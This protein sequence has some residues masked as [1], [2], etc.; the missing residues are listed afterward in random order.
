MDKSVENTEDGK[1]IISKEFF[2]ELMRDKTFLDCLMFVG[3]NGWEGYEVAKE[4][5]GKD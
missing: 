2:E 5:M 3:L 1:V 4:I